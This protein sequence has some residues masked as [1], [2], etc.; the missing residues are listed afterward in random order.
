MRSGTHNRS[1]YRRGVSDGQPLRRAGGLTRFNETGCGGLISADGKIMTAAH[2]VHSMD[3]ID[4]FLG[5]ETL[6]A[7][8][9]SSGPAPLSDGDGPR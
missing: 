1:K 3:Q 5:G 8:L 9:I 2:V 7:R 6:P 4:E